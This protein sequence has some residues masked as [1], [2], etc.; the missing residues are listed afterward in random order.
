MASGKRNHHREHLAY[1]A[2]RILA[3]DGTQDYASAKRKAARQAGAPS[4]QQLPDNRE[5]EA[6]LRSWQALYQR[7]SHASRLQALREAAVTAMKWLAAFNPW[8]TGSV[9]SGTA[10]PHSD[11]NLQLFTDDGK[12]LEL[13]FLNGEQEYHMGQR[14]V[15]IGDRTLDAAVVS[16]SVQGF[17]VNATLLPLDLQ[18]IVQKTGDGRVVERARLV[19]VE[20]LLAAS[21]LTV[22]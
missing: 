10:G 9:W 21:P 11:I 18:R 20:A 1:L 13:F 6:A 14:K 22:T 4:T 8:L 5:I 12:A 2:A 16:F 3:E 19:Q 15:R 17:P 7:E